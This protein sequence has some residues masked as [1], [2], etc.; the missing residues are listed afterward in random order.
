MRYYYRPFV[1]YMQRKWLGKING[2]TNC[3]YL[4]LRRTV[5]ILSAAC[6]AFGNVFPGIQIQGCVFHWVQCVW[7]RVQNLGAQ[8]TY[9]ERTA[10]H[11]YIQKLMALPFLPHQH[12]R[13]ALE[14]LKQLANSLP[15]VDL[16]GYLEET[17]FT[18]SVSTLETVS[19]YKIAV[20]TNNNVE[21][22]NL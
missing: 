2:A 6:I 17:W 10:V 12:M 11:S 15:L 19:V 21:G 22:T 5:I 4:S 7:R 9:V 3:M 16:C 1:F 14:N 13:F 20:R 8:T 18:S